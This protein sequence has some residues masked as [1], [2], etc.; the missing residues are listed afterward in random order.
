MTRQLHQKYCW[1]T[2][3]NHEAMMSSTTA[4]SVN[5][6]DFDRRCFGR[7]CG[8]SILEHRFVSK[9]VLTILHP[10]SIVIHL[11]NLAVSAERCAN[12]Q[13]F[14]RCCF[15]SKSMSLPDACHNGNKQI[16]CLDFQIQARHTPRRS[17]SHVRQL[18]ASPAMPRFLRFART[19]LLVDVDAAVTL[20]L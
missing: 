6:H 8:H 2:F 4:L 17:R 3:I 15:H 11:T 18:H 1:I 9:H 5:W 10:A 12:A 20:E 7:F 13:I 16:K 19:L 14:K